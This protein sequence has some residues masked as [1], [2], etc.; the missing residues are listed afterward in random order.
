MA[1]NNRAVRDVRDKP[2]LDF[3]QRSP[4][5]RCRPLSAE[6][7]HRTTAHMA[8]YEWGKGYASSCCRT[9]RPM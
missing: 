3:G 9:K 6:P 4:L 7:G 5:F 2:A 8:Q 1:K